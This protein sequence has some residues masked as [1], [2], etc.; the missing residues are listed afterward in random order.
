KVPY[1]NRF[2]ARSVVPARET[3]IAF[4]ARPESTDRWMVKT[5]PAGSLHWELSPRGREL[6]RGWL[7]LA[8]PTA[9]TDRTRGGGS[10]RAP[11]TGP[12]RRGGRGRRGRGCGRRGFGEP[13]SW[14]VIS[15]S[16]PCR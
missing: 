9:V 13:P 1:F 7:S 5:R 6:P 11:Q 4:A 14:R 15:S 10:M 8:R 3:H 16:V 2:H 12:P